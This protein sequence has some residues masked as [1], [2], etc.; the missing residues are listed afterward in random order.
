MFWRAYVKYM[1]FYGV[2]ALQTFYVLLSAENKKI[3]CAIIPSKTLESVRVITEALL[4]HTWGSYKA[5]N[6]ICKCQ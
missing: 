4:L 1:H 2:A 3:T 6:T 5:V